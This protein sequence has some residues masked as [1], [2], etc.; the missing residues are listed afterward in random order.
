MSALALVAVGVAP[1]ITARIERAEPPALLSAAHRK[2]LDHQ[3]LVV[4]DGERT[5]MRLWFRTEI[6]VKATEAQLKR[7]LTSRQIP[8]GALVGAV[9][10]PESFIDYRRQRLP[11]G[12][13]TL[14]F[15]LQPETGDHTGT[16]PHPEFCLLSPPNKDRTAGEIEQKQLIQLS[17]QVNEGRHP[18]VL[19]LWPHEEAG[20]AVQV[21]DK[22]NG[23]LA[24]AIRRPVAARK[25]KSQLG[26]AVTVAGSWRQ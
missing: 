20:A 12:T 1:T 21:L 25:R 23:V 3:S 8:E 9:Q 24:V 10:F 5:V 26:L 17:S 15:A 4:R 19:L 13:Y 2:L 14:R 16:S 22:G 11:A 18:A 7:G 6:P